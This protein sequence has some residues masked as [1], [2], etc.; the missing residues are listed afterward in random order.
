MYPF[1]YD[2]FKKNIIVNE[3]RSVESTVKQYNDN[4]VKLANVMKYTLH[5]LYKD[6]LGNQV[7]GF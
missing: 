7:L 5:D 2:G 1:F 6:D 4:D 3:T